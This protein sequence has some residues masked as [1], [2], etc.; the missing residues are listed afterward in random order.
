MLVLM[1][2]A[3]SAIVAAFWALYKEYDERSKERQRAR[4]WEAR[5][6]SAKKNRP[7]LLDERIRMATFHL[8]PLTQEDQN[9]FRSAW[10]RARVQFVDNPTRALSEADRLV[11]QIMYARGV[12]SWTLEHDQATPLA[13]RHPELETQY[14]TAKKIALE[15]GKGRVS[16]AD[17]REALAAYN[18]ICERLLEAA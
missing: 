14:R 7:E 8:R 5:A 3:V 12:P 18:A 2:V 4:V 13:W 1:I 17:L 10:R 6:E 15:S 11:S 16:E 9:N